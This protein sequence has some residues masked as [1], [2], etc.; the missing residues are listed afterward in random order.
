[1]TEFFFNTEDKK[2]FNFEQKK[3]FMTGFVNKVKHSKKILSHIWNALSCLPI[4][5]SLLLF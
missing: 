1:M 2:A 3:L 5:C 4:R